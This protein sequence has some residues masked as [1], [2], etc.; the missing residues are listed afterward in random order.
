MKSFIMSAAAIPA[1]ALLVAG[2]AKFTG[3]KRFELPAEGGAMA[4]S[5]PDETLRLDLVQTDLNEVEGTVYRLTASKAGREVYRS[6]FYRGISGRWSPAT[7]GVFV[8]YV[9][10]SDEM[11]CEILDY[12]GEAMRTVNVRALLTRLYARDDTMAALA[13]PKGV[14]YYL[15]CEKWVDRD[16]VEFSVSVDHGR[17]Y[18]LRYHLESQ[19][20]QYLRYDDDGEKVVAL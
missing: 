5:S 8:N 19:T 3:G 11:G 15:E 9:N 2:C 12:R 14:R 4:V 17:T 6:V 18:H 20:T 7:G 13:A 10:G 1:I 16:T